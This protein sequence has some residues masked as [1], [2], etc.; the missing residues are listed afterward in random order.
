MIEIR[1]IQAVVG[2]VP[3]GEEVEG[4]NSQYFL[5]EKTGLD[6]YDPVEGEDNDIE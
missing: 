1:S 5:A 6:V 4:Q 2:M 3:F